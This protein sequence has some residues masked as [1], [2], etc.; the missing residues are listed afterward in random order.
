TDSL[1]EPGEYLP[2]TLTVIEGDYTIQA[3]AYRTS[4]V[5]EEEHSW[6]TY[7]TLNVWSPEG[8]TVNFTVD[9]NS[10]WLRF[11]SLYRPPLVTPRSVMFSVVH[12]GL[13]PGV[14]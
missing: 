8:A 4:W 2:V 9:N 13:A 5:V 6:N 11:D 1:V 12:S 7:D 14:Y 10:S 3:L